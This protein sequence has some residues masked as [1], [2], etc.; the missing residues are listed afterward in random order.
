M[1]NLF[2]GCSKVYTKSSHLKAH[3]RIHTG[4][5][6]FILSLSVCM[7]FLFY[8]LNI[9]CFFLQGKSHTS[10]SGQNV[11]GVLQDQTN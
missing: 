10:V 6:H 5:L 9:I 8:K 7:K 4:N 11:S 2:S 1:E 3:Q